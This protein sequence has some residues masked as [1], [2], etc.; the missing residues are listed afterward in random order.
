MKTEVSFPSA[1]NTFRIF[2]DLYLPEEFDEN[3]S[4]P[5]PGIVIVSGSGPIDRNGNAPTMTLN[6][7]NRFA[8]HIILSRS[9]ERAIAVFSY[10]KRGTGKSKNKDKNLY[11]RAGMMDLVS[12]AVEAVRCLSSDPRID[13]KKIIVL[14]HSEG[15][16]IMPL[17]CKGVLESGIEPVFGCIFYCGFG[18]NVKDAMDLQADAI[19]KEIR[20]LAGLKGWILRT[21]ASEEKI[22]K[23]RQE[24]FDKV[25]GSDEPDFISMQCG[26]VKQSAKWI[27][28]H[29]AFNAQES[30][31][32]NISCHC[33]AITG[34]KDFQVRDEF[35]KL[36]VARKLVPNAASIEVHRPLNLTHAL[37]SSEGPS[38]I[39]DM[40]KDYAKMG[41]LPLD[42]EM[43]AI[44]DEWLDKVVFEC[45]AVEPAS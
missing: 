40:N 2:G 24:L 12:D 27:R 28:E 16:I 35:C 21:V 34:C 3:E 38:K 19:K 18:E 11:Y 9:P 13:E 39:L 7:S 33:L 37:R 44:T 5:V 20:E 45:G 1:D 23:Q 8:E 32:Q 36:E 41:K 31:A 29:C 30:L 43:L 26:L 6:T 25:N 14:G 4:T 15:A 22:D 42:G 10:D 17:I